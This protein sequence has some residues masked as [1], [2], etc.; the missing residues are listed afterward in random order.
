MRWQLVISHR[1]RNLFRKNSVERETDEELRFHLESQVALHTAAGLSPEEARRAALLE[2]GGVEQFKEECREARGVNRIESLVADLRYGFRSLRKSPGFT[3]VCVLTLALGI[4]ANTAIFSMVNALLLHPYNFRN[5]DSLVRVWEDRGIDE[6]YDARDIAPADAEDL[7]S[8]TGAFEGLTTYSFQAFG[9]GKEGDVQPIFGCRVSANFFDVLAVTPA[10]GR[11]FSAAEERP[12]ADQ[13]AILSHGSWQRRFG[14]DSQLLGKT[15]TLNSRVYTIVGIMPKDFDYPVPVELWVPLALTPAEKADRTQLSLNA[16]ARLKSGV[17]VS[18]ARAV[19]ASFSHR[20]AQEYPKTNAGRSTTLL[21]LR[22]ELYMF[23]LPLFL[24]LQAAAGFVLLLACANLANLVFAR[25]IG[26]QREIALRAALGAGRGRL[27]QLFLSE[28]LLYSFAA[29]LVAIAASFASVRALRTSIPVGWTRWVPGWDGIRVDGNVLAL[30]IVAALSVGLFLGMAAL[31]YTSRVEPNKTLKESGTG[32]VT[33]AKRRVR[34]A[35]VVV[36]VM[37][38]LILLV[39]AGLTIQGFARLA[40]IYQGFE[41]ASV[42]RIEISLPEKIYTDNVKILNF[43]QQLLRGT[44]SL[45]GVQHASLLTN[46]PASNVDTEMTFF[47]IEGQAAL[48]A[49]EMPSADLQIASPDFLDTLKISTVAGRAFAEADNADAPRVALISRGMA[50]R[51]WPKGDAL[52]QRIKL[53]TQDSKDAWLTIVGV[54]GDVRQ[55]W[56][57]PLTRPVIYQPFAQAPQR[58]MALL[59]RTASNPTG[60]VSA[61]REVASQADPAIALREIITLEEEIADSIAIVR[62]MGILMGIFGLV[63]L[64]LS[65]IGV[66]GVLS[67][68]VAQRTHEIGIRLA[69]GANP[70]DLMK[71]ILGQ[72][73]KLT[74]V[75]LLIAIPCAVA[76]SRAMASLIFGVVSLDFTILGAFTALLLLVALGAGYLPARRAIGVDPMVSLRY[77]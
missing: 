47:T 46:P 23:T 52:G 22:K 29:G 51:F 15:I 44:L 43:Y 28:T 10:A 38:A 31:L 25:V 60:Y 12:G 18:Q 67:E 27:G 16:L 20:L 21:Q 11:L 32:T 24:L 4:G 61:V 2:F 55:N 65:S 45:S 56:W 14:A 49:S 9:L 50:A 62:I 73:L 6:G 72:A 19:L 5:L 7:R 40:K 8:T 77:E 13:V 41:P 69:L 66:Y 26:R 76:I 36:Q 39:C 3:I 59:L 54:V 63:A 48:K 30:T 42:L 57:N 1:L 74:G 33:R 35:L 70:R 58:S 34:S 53:G 64:A 71:L 17:S 37:F 68:S 75:G